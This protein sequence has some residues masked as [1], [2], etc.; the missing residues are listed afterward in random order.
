[1]LIRK[2]FPAPAL[3][4]LIL[5]LAGLMAAL[6]PNPASAAGESPLLPSVTPEQL[7]KEPPLTKADIDLFLEFMAISNQLSASRPNDELVQLNREAAAKFLQDKKMSPVRFA[8]IGAKIPIGLLMI[9]NPDRQLPPKFSQP[10][11]I[12]SEA[13][14]KLIEA[15]RDTLVAAFPVSGPPK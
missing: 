14:L 1:M 15:S 5:A 10:Y 12:P 7:Q 6:N 8:Y 11:L 13:E 4:G 3:A 9:M 2:I